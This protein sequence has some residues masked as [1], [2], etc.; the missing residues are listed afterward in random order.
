MGHHQSRASSLD[1]QRCDSTHLSE[2]LLDLRRRGL[3]VQP[4]LMIADGALGFW[5][6]A[7]EVWPKTREQRCWLHKT[8]NVFNKHPGCEVYRWARSHAQDERPSARN[9][10]RLTGPAVTKKRR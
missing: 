5:K 2:P 6:A 9:R 8:A 4:E 10:R 3:D 1:G 7:S